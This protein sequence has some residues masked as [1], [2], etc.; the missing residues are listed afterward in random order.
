[1]EAL[2]WRLRTAIEEDEEFLRTLFA[3]T[4]VALQSFPLELQA[5]LLDMQYRGREMTY[6]TQYPDAEDSMICLDDGTRI[7][8]C[9]VDR[10]DERLRL[11]DLAIVPEWQG[12]GIGTRVLA[13]LAQQSRETGVKLS[14]RIVKENPALRL[15]SRVGFEVETADE[16]SYE[17]VWKEKK[18]RSGL[19]G[20]EEGSVA[21]ETT[22]RLKDVRG[23]CVASAALAMLISTVPMHGQGAQVISTA[24]GTGAVGYTGDNGTATSAT[25]ADPS[26]LAYDANGN[27]YLADAQNHVV[28]EVVKAT[29][30]ITTIAGTGAE[31][32]AG[33]GGAATSTLLDTPTGIAVCVSGILYIADS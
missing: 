10:S 1:M 14:L 17:M 11:V 27:L 6:S 20:R 5:A 28:R 8:R 9:L 29:G 23:L 24:A 32:F 4:N 3:Q 31:G 33:D 7:G 30:T 19:T 18:S 21:S 26:A 13:E 25:L 15:Y 22:G 12:K 16:V 2:G